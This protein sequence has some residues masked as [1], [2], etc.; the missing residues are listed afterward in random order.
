MHCLSISIHKVYLVLASWLG[1]NILSAMGC[2]L[3]RL[4]EAFSRARQA[5]ASHMDWRASA[6]V[7]PGQRPPSA[8]PSTGQ[9]HPGKQQTCIVNM[10]Q[11]S[12]QWCGRHIACR[13]LTGEVRKALHELS[14]NL[15]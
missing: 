2:R 10:M 12:H 3:L 14:L 6:A 15:Q 13:V 11:A 8:P 4:E 9:R 5:L 7:R 1:R